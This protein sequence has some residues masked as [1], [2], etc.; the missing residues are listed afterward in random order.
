MLASSPPP[1]SATAFFTPR[2]LAMVMPADTNI[3]YSQISPQSTQRHQVFFNIII[4]AFLMLIGKI[5]HISSVLNFYHLF[6]FLTLHCFKIVILVAFSSKSHQTFEE[7]SHVVFSY[8][9]ITP[10]SFTGKWYFGLN[11]TFDHLITNNQM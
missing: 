11:Q 1:V 8:I 3:I 9:A 10:A 6:S 2:T 5:N 4:F 7:R